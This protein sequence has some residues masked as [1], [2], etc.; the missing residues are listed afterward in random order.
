VTFISGLAAAGV[1]PREA[2]ALA[3]HS[4][5]K[6]TMQT[7]TDVRLLDLHRAVESAAGDLGS[8]L[9]PMLAPKPVRT[10]DNA[11][12]RRMTEGAGDERGEQPRAAAASGSG[13]I[14]RRA[15]SGAPAQIRTA[16]PGFTKAVLYH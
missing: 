6:L 16:D 2:Q 7:Y 14:S 15:R 3:R 1:H 8:V 13:A 4:D 5:I 12:S 11:S 10:T 9:A